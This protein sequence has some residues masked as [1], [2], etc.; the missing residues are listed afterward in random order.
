LPTEIKKEKR[1]RG[2]G[3]VAKFIANC[4]RLNFV[5]D[6]VGKCYDRFRYWGTLI[7]KEGKHAFGKRDTSHS[8][9]LL[10]SAKWQER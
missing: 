3:K 8:E 6:R 10:K 4:P 9:A 2:T 5:K 1:K 7:Q